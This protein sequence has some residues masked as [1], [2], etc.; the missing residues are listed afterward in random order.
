MTA[1]IRIKIGGVEVECEASESFLKGELPALLAEVSTLYAESGKPAPGAAT[2][3]TSG[4]QGTPATTIDGAVTMFAQKLNAKSGTEL[5]LATA[6]RLTFATGKGSF[7][8]DEISDEMKLATG[9]YKKS[10][11]NNLSNYLINLVKAGDLVQPNSTT[12]ALSSTKKKAMEQ[13][14]A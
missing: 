5:I 3:S 14:L 13:L 6:A 11:M 2:A 10:Y 8:R 9:Y 4:T 12:Y 7:S 1:K